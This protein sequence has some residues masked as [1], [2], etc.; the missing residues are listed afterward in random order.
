MGGMGSGGHN[1]RWRGTVEGHRRLDCLLLRKR[2]LLVDGSSGT[3]TWTS[4]DGEKNFIHVLGG[5]HSIQL[6]YNF[7]R[8]GGAWQ[9]V[10]ETV[11]LDW[12]PRHHGGA[13]PYFGCPKCGSRRRYLIGAGARFLCRACHGLVHAA[14]REGHSDRVF[15]RSWKL[16]RRIGAD[17]AVGG[18]R[19]TRP[20]G[21]HQATYAK[22]LR[23]V[24]ETECAA[25]DD[26]YLA[27][28]R[29]QSR[30]WRK[31]ERARADFWA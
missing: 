8:N 16:K 9:D 30:G 10:C 7:R 6:I 21:M 19:G 15:R 4:G 5:R 3:I 28:L 27:L 18:P 24:E 25:M 29:M 17:L 22:L 31:R 23:A 11:H 2:G 26:S 1:W 20:K 13:Q 14:S 12:S